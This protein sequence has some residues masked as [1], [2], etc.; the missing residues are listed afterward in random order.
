[1]RIAV[2][3]EEIMNKHRHDWAKRDK[4]EIILSLIVAFLGAV[5]VAGLIVLAPAL[6]Q[7]IIDMKG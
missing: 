5:L 7:L 1:M 4:R 3:L 6:D 2:I